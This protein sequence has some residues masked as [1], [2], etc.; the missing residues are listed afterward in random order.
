MTRLNNRFVLSHY[1]GGKVLTRKQP[2]LLS[3]AQQLELLFKDADDQNRYRQLIEAL[4]HQLNQAEYPRVAAI[5]GGQ[6]TGKSTLA[7]LLAQFAKEQG[8]LA[9]TVSLDDYYLSQQQRAGL[10]ATVHPLL[11]LR[12]MPGTHRIEQA[13]L[14]IKNFLNGQAVKLPSFDKALDQPGAERAP[15]HFSLL[16]VEG[17]C[18]GLGPQSAAQLREPV[19]QLESMADPEGHW[20]AYVNQHL[21]QDYQHCW[22]LLGTLIWL[23]AP[24][25]QAICRWRAQQEQELRQVRGI[26]M[27]ETQ[28][29]YFMQTFQRLT[30]HS[31]AVMPSKADIIIELNNSHQ[32]TLL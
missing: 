1:K 2:Q 28:L 25:W 16:I 10:A 19:N 20:R 9:G 22:S 3:F 30:E 27:S 8:V 24:D 23:K 14:D 12:G 17:W 29:H 6:G 7:R 11:A 5:S 31:F 18:L 15:E 26:A 13:I 21:A 32:P 4:W